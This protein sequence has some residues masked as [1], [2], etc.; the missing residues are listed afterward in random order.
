MSVV[1][2][3]AI[4]SELI[5]NMLCDLK[6]DQQHD[7]NCISHV[8]IYVPHKYVA[9]IDNYIE[10]LN[11]VIDDSNELQTINDG[12]TLIQCFDM[13]IYFFDNEYFNY[14]M[15]QLFN[16]WLLL[17]PSVHDSS[18]NPYLQRQILLHCPYQMLPKV[19]IDDKIFFDAWMQIHE[20][21]STTIGNTR[22]FVG[23]ICNC[24]TFCYMDV[25][26][27]S[28]NGSKVITYYTSGRIESEGQYHQD[29]IL[30]PG[31]DRLHSGEQG[32]WRR[33]EDNEDHSP[34]W[35]AQYVNGE[36]HCIERCWYPQ[37]NKDGK[38]L[39]RCENEY[40]KGH[41]IRHT[42]WSKVRKR[43]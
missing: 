9:I 1:Y 41:Q 43:S 27:I 28:K 30:L 15:C 29:G 34:I 42:T 37:P 40:V 3:M 16:N 39:V 23:I 25:N 18:I 5:S 21:K 13:C 36:K 35:E 20:H 24:Y 22:Y 2:N 4:R 32:L 8:T 17:S 7:N 33:W 26:N 19:Y 6:L 10:K 12:D 31:D 38:Y 14:L 11:V